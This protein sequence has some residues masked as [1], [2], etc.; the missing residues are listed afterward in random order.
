MSF[1]YRNHAYRDELPKY[2]YPFEEYARLANDDVVIGTDLLID[3]CFFI[4]KP[5]VFPLHISSFDGTAGTTGQ[6]AVYVSDDEGTSQGSALVTVSSENA[7]VTTAEG[8][9]VGMLLFNT[10]VLRR[11]CG[12][13]AGK[14]VP[15]QPD[16]APFSLDVCHALRSNTVRHIEA[17]GSA[18]TG[19]VTLVARHGCRFAVA[20]GVVQ[21]D[22]VGD[23]ALSAEQN[24]I[25]TINGVGATSL[26]LTN[27]PTTNVRV[28]TSPTGIVLES[29]L[30]NRG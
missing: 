16:V 12:S 25:R 14:L 26:W 9:L 30:D 11:F 23:E 7:E 13:V 15:C 6:F 28:D 4:K 8:V 22:I 2:A 20:A 21:L 24:P 3:A 18:V 1:S 27:S 29:I 19:A 5:V 10:A 17:G